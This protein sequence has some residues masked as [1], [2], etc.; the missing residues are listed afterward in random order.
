MTSRTV[1][2]GVSGSIAAYKAADLCSKLV[3]AGARVLPILTRGALRFVAPATFHGLTGEPVA[4]DAFEE[5]FPGEIAHLA[6]AEWADLF[7]LAP[8]SADL[9]AR[10]A[11]GLCDDMLTT[12]LLANRTK[13]VLVAPAMNSDMWA[14][15]AVAA[16]RRTLEGWGYRFLE[17]GVG[18]LAEGIVGA[19]R[20]PEPA[21]ILAAIEEMLR[22][23]AGD[24]AGRTVLVTA[25]PTRTSDR[26]RAGLETLATVM[27]AVLQAMAMRAPRAPASMGPKPQSFS[28]SRTMKMPGVPLAMGISSMTQR[29][30]PV[31]LPRVKASPGKSIKW[32]RSRWR[33]YRSSSRC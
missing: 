7:V 1:V 9:L 11:S 6:Y 31:T 4:T 29:P 3:Q 25:G 18:R 2:L 19:G 8:A 20:L 24:L 27:A 5:P 15:P 32:R 33:R 21:E 17:P 14:H 30:V 22:T 23:P 13:P 16:N 28:S 26:R 10:L 12:A